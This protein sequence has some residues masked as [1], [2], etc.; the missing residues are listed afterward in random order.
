MKVAAQISAAEAAEL[1]HTGDT[2]VVGG[3][4]M[5]GHPVH[6]LHAIAATDVRELTYIGN[7]VGEPGLG[8]GRL[9]RQ[10]QIAKAIGSFFTSNPEAVKAAQS[11]TIEVELLP[12]DRKSV[13]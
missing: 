9:L 11:E 5:T 1:I 8:G 7:N 6:L 12:Q 10:G 13:V 3:F 2:L 4:G